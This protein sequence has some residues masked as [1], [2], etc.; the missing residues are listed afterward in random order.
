ME[1][2]LHYPV[3]N[4]GHG[5]FAKYSSL[6]SRV[7]NKTNTQLTSDAN[8]FVNAKSHACKRE[9]SARRLVQR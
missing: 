3:I 6:V 2:F 4:Y 8:D 5:T 9:T 1:L 7:L